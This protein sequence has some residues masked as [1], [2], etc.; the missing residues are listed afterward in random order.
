MVLAMKRAQ[1]A[2]IWKPLLPAL[3]ISVLRCFALSAQ[4][5]SPVSLADVRTIYVDSLGQGEDPTIIRDKIINRMVASGRFQVVLDPDKADAVL[6][7]SASEKSMVRY[8]NGTGGTRFDATV[9]VRLVTKD[10]RILWTS[11]AKNG[12]FFSPSASSSVAA[13]IVKELLKAASPSKK[14]SR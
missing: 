14:A 9:V 1:A 7:G 8:A 10:Q 6:A 4:T 5:Q 13:N 2:A 12:H 11:E 3:V